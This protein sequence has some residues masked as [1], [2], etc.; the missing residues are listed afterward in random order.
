MALHTHI[1]WGMNNRPLV[2]S[3]QRQSH[4]IDVNQNNNSSNSKVAVS[5]HVAAHSKMHV[6]L[7]C[8]YSGITGSI[9]AVCT[10]VVYD[11]L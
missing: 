5:I 10:V 4:H 1:M 8:S 6:A 3:I 11:F 7:N 2:A 9:P